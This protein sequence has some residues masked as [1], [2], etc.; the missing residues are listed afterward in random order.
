MG[1]SGTNGLPTMTESS[2]FK[3]FEAGARQIGYRD[4]TTSHIAIKSVPYDGR[5]ACTQIGFCTSGCA[6]GAK[7]S[8]LYTE[9]PR[10]ESTGH[11]E[12][13]ATCMAVRIVM[14]SRGLVTGVIY[15]D[16]NGTRHEQK[17]RAVSSRPRTEKGA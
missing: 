12:L 5:P 14:D 3:V 2:Q 13:R 1:V 7:W 8:T 11:F 15:R 4:I 16:A 6:T 10:A 17:A 9:I